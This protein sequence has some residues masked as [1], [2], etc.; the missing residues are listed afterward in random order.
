MV[1]TDIFETGH[2]PM[3]K[4]RHVEPSERAGQVAKSEGLGSWRDSVGI[5]R[6]YDRL[7]G[8]NLGVVVIFAPWPF[9]MMAYDAAPWRDNGGLG[10]SWSGFLASGIA[11]LAFLALAIAAVLWMVHRLRV[12]GAAMHFFEHGAVAERP[13][14]KLAVFR[15][16]E[17]SPRFVV[18]DEPM[19][20][21]GIRKRVQLWITMPVSGYQLC[22]DGM[23]EADRAALKTIAT[24]LGL[25]PEP[26]S[27]GRLRK[28][29]PAAF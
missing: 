1:M 13:R 5:N 21:G 27:I 29:A 26:E 10:R 23:K 28:Q 15:Y 11:G 14:G 20:H 12:G 24:A 4:V 25:S 3:K 2:W 22:L 16:A 6:A 18:W 9:L 19:D 8:M 7:M 17:V